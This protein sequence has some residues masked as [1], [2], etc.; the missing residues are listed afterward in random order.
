MKLSYLLIV[1][2]CWTLNVAASETGWADELMRLDSTYDQTKPQ[3]II[4]AY[5]EFV[6][7]YKGDSAIKSAAYRRLGNSY[8]DIGDY[9]RALFYQLRALDLND[10]F[11]G[12]LAKGSG[13]NNIGGLYYYLG[14]KEQATRYFREA[15]K[16]FTKAREETEIGIRGQADATM[17]LASTELEL[18]H[19][20]NARRNLDL[21]FKYTSEYGDS[22]RI[23]AL[24]MIGANI[25]EA[26]HDTLG[27]KN[28]LSEVQRCLNQNYD[29]Y[30]AHA[31]EISLA[32]YYQT[33]GL[34]DSVPVV[35]QRA[36]E[37][38]YSYQSPESIR[39]S[40]HLL[41]DYY[42]LVGD[43][44]NAFQYLKV[45]QVFN[46]S[47]LDASRIQALID[48]EQKYQNVA[49]TQELA[50]QEQ[51]LKRRR[52]QL[53]SL[54]IFV[55][56]LLLLAIALIQNRNKTKRLAEKELELKDSQITEL[57]QDQEL[58]S[59][60]AML[61]GQ[62]E[63]RQ[64]IA[65]DLHDRLGSILSTVKLHFSTMED[66]IRKLQEKQNDNY[67]TATRMLDEAVEEVRKISHD[68]HSGT[69]NR[70]G[71][72]TALLQLIHAIEGANT[73]KIHFIDNQIDPEIFSP[74]EVELYRI[75]QE[76]LSNTLKHAKATEVTIQLTLQN[77][78]VTFSYEDNGVGMQ[79]NKLA[80]RGIGLESIEKRV[81]KIKGSSNIDSTPGHGFTMIIEIPI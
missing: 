14:E 59:I 52:V 11:G 6:E 36:L 35:L 33:L 37:L 51:E 68:L 7:K 28:Y 4:K 27:W 32:K 66:E 15:Y 45:Y 54:G 71:L 16:L 13:Y 40:A 76:L 58:K 48:A 10:Y 69:I 9:E 5:L 73:I 24:Y 74:F 8:S 64:R 39:Q 19:L 60:D 81:Q 17:N 47:L 72:K 57:M 67:H 75:I 41:A 44:V 26:A 34:M 2:F 22:S 55:G 31:A 56:L 43:S 77:G 23:H 25:S 62:D 38:A 1:F 30:I 78:F 61:K 42:E 49:K 79:L 20:E 63:E 12:A 80:K 50:E 29:L 21:A 46:D 18:G 3:E 70:F 53:V 65:R